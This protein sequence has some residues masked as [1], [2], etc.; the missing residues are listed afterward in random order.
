LKKLW[1]SSA[2]RWGLGAALSLFSGWW[3]LQSLPWPILT[4]AEATG[5]RIRQAV[6]ALEWGWL[7]LALF[8]M[9]LNNLF[10]V[11]RWK[12]ILGEAGRAIPLRQYLAG[13]LVGQALNILYPAR[14]GEL[15]RAQWIG[16]IGPGRVYTL[17]SLFLEKFADTVCYAS[18]F[19]VL[20]AAMPFPT[21]LRDSSV[22]VFALTAAFAGLVVLFF[23][24]GPWLLQALSKRAPRALGARLETAAQSGLSSLEVLRDRRRITE[25]LGW[26]VMIW[27]TAILNNALALAAFRLSLPLSAPILVLIVLQAGIT[28]PGLPGK[29]GLFQAACIF[30]LAVFHVPE[31]TALG[32]SLVL[33]A[34]VMLPISLAGIFLMG[35]LTWK[36]L[37]N[38]T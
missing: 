30:S 21:W 37:P 16:A 31:T 33:Q 7:C 26:S 38:L 17:G 2:F 36:P 6:G 22:G 4:D 5:E 20:M 3:A 9:S 29:V 15:A 11:V 8:S 24:R 25:I 28:L 34:I 35:G 23:T 12:A 18:L 1:Q 32:Y 14:L 19:L 27:I 13:F 10:K